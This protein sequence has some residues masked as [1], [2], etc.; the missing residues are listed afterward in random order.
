LTN[1]GC[2]QQH[3]NNVPVVNCVQISASYRT[4]NG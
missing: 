2:E 1:E 3:G 4:R